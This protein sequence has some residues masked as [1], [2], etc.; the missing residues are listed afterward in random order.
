M[1][2]PFSRSMR[3]LERDRFLGARWI[4]AVG[5]LLLGAWLLWFFF[6]EVRL[7]EV[8]NRA[9]IE[10]AASSYP[11]TAEVSG[12][13][14][15]IH[16]T[17]GSVVQENDIL[18]ELAAGSEELELEEER[19]RVSAFSG[20]AAELA[21][22]IAA[23]RVA[24]KK[25]DEAAMSRIVE[26]EADFRGAE[27]LANRAETA[28]ERVQS[29]HR[30]GLQS[31]EKLD[32]A[33][34][35]LA[36]SKADLQGS[37]AAITTFQ[38]ER[39][40]KRADGEARLRGMV[41]E[42]S[43][44]EGRVETGERAE[45]RLGFEVGRRLIRATAA[46]RLGDVTDIRVGSFV[47]EG[48]PLCKIVPEGDEFIVDAYYDPGQALGRIRDGQSAELRLDGYPWTQYGTVSATVREVGSEVRNGE[49]QVRLAIVRDPA[50]RI[51]LDHGLPGTLEIEVERVSPAI[52]VLRSAGQMISTPALQ[53]ADS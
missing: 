33:R 16:M 23:E 14:L 35:D 26:A 39:D 17:L 45:E 21:E 15:A 13:V 46:G 29:L 53:P 3:S 44:L 42:L 12:R 30:D 48:D 7:Y 31:D 18:V 1:A 2:I 47:E 43:E 27:V 52:L 40:A 38:Q 5:V 32:E 4:L 41:R 8:A 6:S 34:S 50:S 24:L 37:R 19:S 36:A 22:Q 51:P 20:E 10:V 25:Q 28:F 9:R 49:V 11:V